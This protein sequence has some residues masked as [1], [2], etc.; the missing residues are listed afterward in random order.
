MLTRLMSSPCFTF[1]TLFGNHSSSD[2]ITDDANDKTKKFNIF[3][4]PTFCGKTLLSMCVYLEYFA[5]HHQTNNLY[6]M[7]MILDIDDAVPVT[8]GQVGKL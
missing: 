8:R 5:C 1:G 3:V 2:N 4:I 7:C 6:E